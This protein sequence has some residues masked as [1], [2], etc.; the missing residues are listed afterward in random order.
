M[1]FYFL[2]SLSEEK[3]WDRYENGTKLVAVSARR[4]VE[5]KLTFHAPAASETI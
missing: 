5:L 1:Y 4:E 3:R 2:I